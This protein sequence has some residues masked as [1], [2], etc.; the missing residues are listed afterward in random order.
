[1]NTKTEAEKAGCG[2]LFLLWFGLIATIG[3]IF[4]CLI[5]Y[6]LVRIAIHLSH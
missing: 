2:I 5:G 4:T 3:V 6:I 1:M